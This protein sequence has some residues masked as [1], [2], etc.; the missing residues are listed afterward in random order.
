[1]CERDRETEIGGERERER[2]RRERERET[3]MEMNSQFSRNFREL[4]FGNLFLKL[5]FEK[6]FLGNN[7]PSR[8]LKQTKTILDLGLENSNGKIKMPSWVGSDQIR[9]GQVRS[10]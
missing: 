6:Q 5:H 3:M 8:I 4:F 7:F 9:S 2:E 1:V 10:G